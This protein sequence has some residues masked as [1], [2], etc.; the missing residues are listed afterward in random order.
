MTRPLQVLEGGRKRPHHTDALAIALIV[1]VVV[2]LL[3][4]I[5]CAL[6]FLP[7]L[8]DGAWGSWSA[9]VLP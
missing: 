1:V 3:A 9:E 7:P 6:G 5:A 2:L 4:S 8:A